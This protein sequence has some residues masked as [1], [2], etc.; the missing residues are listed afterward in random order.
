MFNFTC[1]EGMEPICITL[2]TLDRYPLAAR[3][4]IEAPEWV[5]IWREELLNQTE[6]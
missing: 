4:A 6:I 3:I 2:P 1:S 5:E